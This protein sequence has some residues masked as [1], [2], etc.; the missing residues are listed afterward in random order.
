MSMLQLT[1]HLDQIVKLDR[2]IRA[3]QRSIKPL[4]MDYA[5]G[6]DV[7]NL[8]FI[9]FCWFVCQSGFSMLAMWQ[10]HHDGEWLHDDPSTTR[11]NLLAL[12]ALIAGTA[13]GFIVLKWWE[14]PQGFFWGFIISYL[15]YLWVQDHYFRAFVFVSNGLMIATCL[16]LYAFYFEVIDAGPYSRYFGVQRAS[17]F[18]PGRSPNLPPLEDFKHFGDALGRASACGLSNSEIVVALRRMNDGL[19][20]TL[21][22]RG[23]TETLHN[24]LRGNMAGEMAAGLRAQSWYFDRVPCGEVLAKWRKMKKILPF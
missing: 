3:G 17:V 10:I 13:W 12:F 21:E 7:M 5:Q 22:V 20:H 23:I 9:V 19:A 14:V 2:G 4:F 16:L 11:F 24:E 1:A 6:P 15:I 8:L 18:E